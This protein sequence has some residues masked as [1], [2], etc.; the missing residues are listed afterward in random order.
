MSEHFNS[1]DT[2]TVSSAEDFVFENNLIYDSKNPER[3]I[4]F[5]QA[6]NLMQFMRVSLSAT[7]FYRTPGVFFDREKGQGNPFYYFTFGMAV[8]EV[9]VDLLTGKVSVLRADILHDVGQSLNPEIDRGQIEG[10]YVQG[11]GW[12]LF[13]DLRY[14]EKGFLLNN[15]Q[16]LTK[17]LLLMIF[18]MNST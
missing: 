5:A 12:T 13:E 10:A 11:M 2:S 8:T 17:Y 3:K 14:N 6:A 9:E 1:Q 4:T 15:R 7:G 18:P 16:E